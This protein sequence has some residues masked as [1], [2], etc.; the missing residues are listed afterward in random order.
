MA[1][2]KTS[3]SGLLTRR[4]YTSFL[5]GNTQF[6]AGNYES[7]ATTTVGAT[8]VASITFSSIS[9]TYTHLQLRG[10]FN[11]ALNVQALLRLNSDSGSNYSYHQLEG[12]GSSAVAG[13]DTST[14][15]IIHFINGME[16]GTTAGSAFVVDILDYA[17]TNKYKTTRALTGTD[18]NGSGQIFL[19]SGNW[20]NTNA[21]TDISLTTNTGTF[22]QYTQIALYGIKG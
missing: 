17:N 6:V 11:S 2:Y 13:A 1:V 9:A 12:N 4:E 22:A 20:R 16:S 7:I 19:V 3:N 5:A 14:T 10:I 15:S 21:V 8:S 18:K